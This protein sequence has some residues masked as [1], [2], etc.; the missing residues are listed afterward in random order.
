M[1]QEEEEYISVRSSTIYGANCFA[2]AGYNGVCRKPKYCKKSSFSYSRTCGW[3]HICCKKGPNPQSK[4]KPKRLRKWWKNPSSSTTSQA[5]KTT[6]T[7]RKPKGPLCGLEG[8]EPFIFGGQEAKPGQFPF[9]VS[10]VYEYRPGDVENF[11]GGVLITSRHVLTA[12]H[13]FSRKRPSEWSQSGDI[14]VRIGLSNLEKREHDPA[15]IKAV[16]IHP[17]YEELNG[18]RQGVVNDFCIVTLDRDV[19]SGQVCL[20]GTRTTSKEGNNTKA[21]VIGFGKTTQS[22]SVLINTAHSY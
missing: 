22:R 9:M 2:S 10:F 11:C 7:T 4:A 12:A 17:D 16:T 18:G 6:T 13:C 20:G 1:D 15:N 21:V 14:D 8:S 5:P 3:D 19:N